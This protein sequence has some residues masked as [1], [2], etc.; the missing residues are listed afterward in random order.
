MVTGLWPVFE[1]AKAV[2]NGVKKTAS[3]SD[4]GIHLMGIAF[5]DD[6]PPLMLA[7]LTTQ[8]GRDIQSGYRFLFMGSQQAIRNPSAHEQFAEMDGDEAFELLGPANLLMR[9][10]DAVI[11]T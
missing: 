4:D 7:E 9:R 3:L 10:L 11:R 2:N 8:T 6:Q 1:A 5:K